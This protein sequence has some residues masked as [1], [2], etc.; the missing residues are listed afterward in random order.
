MFHVFW[1]F[2]FHVNYA[3]KTRIWDLIS[4]I[5]DDNVHLLSK[6]SQLSVFRLG[7]NACKLLTTM[8]PTAAPKQPASFMCN[9]WS[10]HHTTSSSPWHCRP[11]RD[12]RP[13][14][15]HP[16]GRMLH[17]RHAVALTKSA[18]LFSAAVR[19]LEGRRR[20]QKQT[21]RFIP[22][23]LGL[24]C[25][26]WAECVM[27][28]RG[29]G[30]EWGSSKG[31]KN[32]IALISVLCGFG[33]SWGTEAVWFRALAP[34]PL[35]RSLF[36]TEN[37]FSWRPLLNPVFRRPQRPLVCDPAGLWTGMMW[38][39]ARIPALSGNAGS[40]HFIV[41]SAELDRKTFAIIISCG[42]LAGRSP[43]AHPMPPE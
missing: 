20:R 38:M 35:T 23:L 7:L 34:A 33:L 13:L 3:F 41:P 12:M 18:N 24:F 9:P 8:V 31:V 4:C 21:V 10:H 2:H 40:P 22:L 32:L 42:V 30:G 43:S 15:P 11:K 19:C 29:A 1:G 26:L 37:Q 28:R 14:P 36:S 16:E 17:L 39:S 6:S 5:N 25:L 27:W